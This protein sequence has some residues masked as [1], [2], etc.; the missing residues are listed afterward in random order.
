MLLGLAEISTYPSKTPDLASLTFDPCSTQALKTRLE[1]VRKMK[2]LS[3]PGISVTVA[4]ASLSLIADKGPSQ[5]PTTR[6]SPH[7]VIQMCKYFSI[8]KW[9]QKN[10]ETKVTLLQ[11]I[12]SDI[13]YSIILEKMLAVNY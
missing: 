8:V 6:R 1:R 3:Y 9:K 12:H 5:R 10:S 11:V 2:C 13:S 4:M 7:T